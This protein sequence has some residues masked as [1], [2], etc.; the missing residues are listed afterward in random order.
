MLSSLY[1]KKGSYFMP[2]KP[3]FIIP[4][5]P[6]HIVQRGHSRDP[7]FFEDADYLAYLGWL[8]S[9]LKGSEPFN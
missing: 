5:V 6:V 3:R 9:A 1:L 2:R 7:V 8:K 4:N